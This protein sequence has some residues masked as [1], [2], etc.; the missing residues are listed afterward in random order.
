MSKFSG[1]MCEVRQCYSID[2]KSNNNPTK[3]N[4]QYITESSIYFQN[5]S[6]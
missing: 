5:V 2:L 6:G 3:P 1:S 4:K